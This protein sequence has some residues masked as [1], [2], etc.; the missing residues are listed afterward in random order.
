MRTTLV[1]L[2]LAGCDAAAAPPDITTLAEKTREARDRMH[3]R[4][5]ATRRMQLAISIGSLERAHD[6]AKIVAELDEPDA[7]PQWRPYVDKIRAGARQVV[8][9]KDTVVAARASAQL[10]RECAQC[11]VALAAKIAFPKEPTPTTDPK[12]AVQMA[13]HQ[14]A[15]ARMWEG[16][17]GPSDERWALGAKTLAQAPL[18]IVARGNSDDGTVDDVARVRLFANRALKPKSASERAE[19]YGDML[20]TCAHCHFVIRD[21]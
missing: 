13:S 3:I 18:T 14:W 5:D 6:E 10:G 17:I 8:A 2:A 19:L 20:A 16:L 4:F 11:H 12:L 15:A 7:L 1:L 9:A 21:R